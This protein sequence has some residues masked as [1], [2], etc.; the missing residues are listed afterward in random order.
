MSGHDDSP[1]GKSGYV[2][3]AIP[4]DKRAGEVTV[5]I[6]GGTESFIAFA[7]HPIERG[8][9][10]LVVGDRGARSVDVVGLDSVAG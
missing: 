5:S 2:S 10:V 4:G 6:R 9:Q 8:R 3:V 1:A 7:E